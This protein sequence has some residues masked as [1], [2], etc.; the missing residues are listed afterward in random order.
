MSVFVTDGDQRAT[1][2]LVRALGGEGIPVTVG[3]VEP[4]SLAGSSRYCAK[5]VRYPSPLERGEDFQAYLFDEIKDGRYRV[6]LPMTDVTTRLVAQMHEAL[7]PL[8]R[9]PVSSEEQIRRAQDKRHVLLLAQQLGIACP[10]TSMLHEGESL[11]AVTQRVRYPVV[12]KPRFSWWL[13]NGEWTSGNVQYAHDPEELTAKYHESHQLIPN[14]LIQEKIEGEGQGVFLLLWNG[15]LKAAFCHRR[16]REKP[17]SGGVSVLCESIAFDQELVQKSF[18]LLQAIGWKGP[19]MVEFKVDR[20]DGQAKLMEVNGR[21]WGSLQLAIDAGVNFPLLL[22]RLA[23]GENVSSQFSYKLGVKSRWLLGDL[24]HLWIR[25]THPEEANGFSQSGVSK[26]RACL[27]FIKLYQRDMHYEVFRFE[28]RGPGW[29][30][31]KSYVRQLLRG[32]GPRTEGANA[33]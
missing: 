20:R 27:N 13:R 28:D 10:A 14:P 6:L 21:F 22:Y 12:I 16:L 33:R 18:S 29:Y 7:A 11:A 1:L 3:S 9:V 31:M 17:P 32:S 2:A 24:D 23:N 30:E 19:A 25:L 26:V 5:R 8:V 15:Q 4:T